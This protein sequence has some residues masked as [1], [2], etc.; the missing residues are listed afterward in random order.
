[1]TVIAL[2]SETR[3]LSGALAGRQR[4]AAAFGS[5]RFGTFATTV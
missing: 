5:W 4:A 1:M 2:M 3:G